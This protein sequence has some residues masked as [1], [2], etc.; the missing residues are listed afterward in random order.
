MTRSAELTKAI[1]DYLNL[2]GNFVWR[3]NTTG[4]YDPTKKVF[5]KNPGQKKGVA[6]IC[7]ITK[8]GR[9][10]FVEVKTTDKMS[11]D[12]LRFKTEIERRHG[13]F[14]EARK[15]EDITESEY[16]L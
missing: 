13:I 14:I 5:R 4:L 9:G 1:I 15:L 11:K 8:T 16:G 12:Q 10:L 3:N 2:T 6:D 7:G